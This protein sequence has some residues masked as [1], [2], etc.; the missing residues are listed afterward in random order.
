MN[1]KS[2]KKQFQA[3]ALAF[4]NQTGTLNRFLL[5]NALKILIR[6]TVSGKMQEQVM[7]TWLLVQNWLLIDN[8]SGPK[9][10]AF[11]SKS[12]TVAS[13]V[14]LGVGGARALIHPRAST[15]RIQ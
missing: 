8:V 7:V 6:I 13:L 1:A 11:Q 12:P 14:A 10:A 9:F 2:H 4:A 3:R 5:K 15:G